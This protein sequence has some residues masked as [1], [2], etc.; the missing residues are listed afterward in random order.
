MR[1]RTVAMNGSIAHKSEALL[2]QRQEGAT[3]YCKTGFCKG[4][5]IINVFPVSHFLY[6][7]SI[8]NHIK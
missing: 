4:A 3:R 2:W 8:T 1:E 5:L 6:H 7:N